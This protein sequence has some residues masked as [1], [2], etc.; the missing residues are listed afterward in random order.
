[1]LEKQTV[2]ENRGSVIGIGTRSNDDR[3]KRRAEVTFLDI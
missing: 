2:K 3:R 1:M